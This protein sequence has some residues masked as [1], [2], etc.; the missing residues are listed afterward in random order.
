MS[1]DWLLAMMVASGR[2]ALGEIDPDDLAEDEP[3]SKVQWERIATPGGGFIDKQ[4]AATSAHG[5]RRRLLV[6]EF[7]PRDQEH[8]RRIEAALDVL[9]GR[10]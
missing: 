10:R 8:A 6:I 9:A 4:F 5:Y 3:T 2:D 7:D 1:N